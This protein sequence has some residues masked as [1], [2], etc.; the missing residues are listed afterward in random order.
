MSKEAGFPNFRWLL[1]PFFFVG[2][3]VFYLLL[4]T[5]ELLAV[6]FWARP[7]PSLTPPSLRLACLPEGILSTVRT[8]LSRAGLPG[9]LLGP[10]VYSAG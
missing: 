5:A 10:Y 3:F 2:F 6:F 8:H 4:G 1:N 9:T 7:L